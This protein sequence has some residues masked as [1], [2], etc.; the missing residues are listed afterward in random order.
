MPQS[1][2]Q[3]F[4]FWQLNRGATAPASGATADGVVTVIKM[5]H[6]R[7]NAEEGPVRLPVGGENLILTRLRAD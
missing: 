1:R 4:I 2:N 3:Y 6:I 5:G 7:Q